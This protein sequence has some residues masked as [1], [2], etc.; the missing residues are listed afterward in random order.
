M[1]LNRKAMLI[2][3]RLAMNGKV[4]YFLFTGK[5][6][7]RR[8]KNSCFFFFSLVALNPRPVAFSHRDE[9]FASFCKYIF[10]NLCVSADRRRRHDSLS[11]SS[12]RLRRVSNQCVQD[13][14]QSLLQLTCVTVLYFQY[15][16]LP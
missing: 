15:V 10:S 5:I 1:T 2:M 13:L 7:S 14:L 3:N 12:F 16:C 6:T 11:L 8:K 9:N 4:N